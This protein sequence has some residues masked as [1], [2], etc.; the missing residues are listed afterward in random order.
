MAKQKID[1]N[2]LDF[3]P[4]KNPEI[5]YETRVIN[6]QNIFIVADMPD[7]TCLLRRMKLQERR[8]L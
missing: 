5:K 7:Q 3:I 4:V 2:Y 1:K 6:M 8:K